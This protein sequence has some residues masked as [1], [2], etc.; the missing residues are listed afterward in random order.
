MAESPFC[1]C[2]LSLPIRHKKKETVNL[3][4]TP[5]IRRFPHQPKTTNLNEP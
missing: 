2:I 1:F 3:S 4:S 5:A